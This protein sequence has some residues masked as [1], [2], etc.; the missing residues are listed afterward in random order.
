MA[1][2]ASGSLNGTANLGAGKLAAE[3]QLD[4][5]T[6]TFKRLHPRT[7]L[8]RFL[9]SHIR[10]DGRSFSS[11]RPTSIVSGAISSADG[12]CL[13]RLGVTTVVAG[14]KAEIAKPDAA[15]GPQGSERGWLV[16][17]IESG[18]L[19]SA[20]G[21]PGPPTEEAQIVCDRL[22][23]ILTSTSRPILD[24]TSLCI[25]KDI[26]AWC[27]YL[28]ITVISNDG[29]VLDAAVLAAVGALQN[30]GSTQKAAR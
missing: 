6:T 17:N 8:E 2:A 30:C 23:E 22:T 27:L 20:R 15:R 11:W 3:E 9:S 5:S 7:Y 25:E 24:A 28:D 12:S 10:E 13:V 19:S 4:L 18:P 14:I 1:A 26:A 16:P 21:R 29:N